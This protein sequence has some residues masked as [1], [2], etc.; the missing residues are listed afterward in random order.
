[1]SGEVNISATPPDIGDSNDVIR[2]EDPWVVCDVCQ[3]RIAFSGYLQHAQSHMTSFIPF[4]MNGIMQLFDASGTPT[5]VIQNTNN[6]LMVFMMDGQMGQDIQ[7]DPEEHDDPMAP[8]NGLEVDAVTQ[9]VTTDTVPFLDENGQP[10]LCPICYRERA[11][12]GIEQLVETIVCKHVFCKVCI[13]HWLHN[14]CHC[15]TCRAHLQ[16]LNS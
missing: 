14:H 8:S 3:E 5:L 7:L 13:E 6:Q 15:P 4:P 16:G 11:E 12:C 1:M 9:P 2:I 10:E